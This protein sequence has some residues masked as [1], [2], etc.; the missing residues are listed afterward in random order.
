MNII[1]GTAQFD[2]KYGIKN[3]YQKLNNKKITNIIG[4]AEKFGIDMLDTADSYGDAHKILS[5]FNLSKFKI[6]SKITYKKNLTKIEFDDYISNILKRLKIKKIYSI[7]LHN[8]N[9]FKIADLENYFLYLSNLKNKGII[10]KIG[11]SIYDPSEFYIYSKYFL[12]DIVQG[13]LNIFDRRFIKSNFLNELKSK[14]I[15]FH[16]RSIFL[17]GLVLMKSRN[18]YF[19]KWESYFELL[20][21]ELNNTNLKNYEYALN[22]VK[23]QKL[24]NSIIFGVD[25]SQHIKNFMNSLKIKNIKINDD[26]EIN[27]KKIINPTQWKL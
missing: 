1:L 18:K 4:T 2:L 11:F 7:L 14:K 25:S 5:Q 8:P 9:K 12:P 13:P 20:N 16:A 6:I 22:Y 3:K 21:K 10:S 26:L 19:D 27:D 17:Q 23:Q 15:E 24:V